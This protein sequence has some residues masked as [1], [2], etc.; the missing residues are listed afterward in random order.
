MTIELLNG[1]VY[2]IENP[3]F[4]KDGIFAGDYR[5]KRFF[6]DS[7]PR[8]EKDHEWMNMAGMWPWSIVQRFDREVAA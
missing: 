7:L 4:D 1:T 3:V 8:E 5:V 2:E 6:R